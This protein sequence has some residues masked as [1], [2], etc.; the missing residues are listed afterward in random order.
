MLEGLDGEDVLLRPLLLSRTRPEQDDLLGTSEYGE[1]FC[2]AAGR[3]N[4]AAVQFHPEKSSR[5][6][7]ELYENFL[8]GRGRPERL[9]G[10]S[11]HRP[12]GRQVRAPACR[13]TSGAPTEYDADPVERAREWERRGAKALHVV[14]L[15][16][17]VE[18][19]AGSA[20]AGAEMARGR[21]RCPSRSVVAFGRSRTCGPCGG[22]GA[23]DRARHRRPCGTGTS[24]CG[25]SKS[26]G[27]GLVVAVD[28]RDGVVATHGWRRSSG[29]GVLDLAEELACDGVA[30]VLFTDVSRDGTSAGARAL[31]ETAA[32]AT[33]IPTIA[34]GGVR[35]A[36]DVAA[37][38]K[39]HGVV[40]A[41]VGTALY[42]G[43]VTLEELLAAE[44][45]QD[46]A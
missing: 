24:G 35:D 36:E 4:L 21:W 20:G 17:A 11:G 40:G 12:A 13:G 32:V 25:R 5:A 14:D 46:L 10:L 9:H 43:R 1:T 7:L 22:R 34:S 19:Q 31:E 28:A 6:G 2:A 44:R 33:L 39:L 15:D 29:I 8:G 3:E 18:G 41:V 38:A 45:G 30:T 37:L 26:S 42:E 23:T 16:G 27:P